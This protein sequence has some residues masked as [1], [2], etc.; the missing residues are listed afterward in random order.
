MGVQGGCSRGV[1]RLE[2]LQGANKK[3]AELREVCVRSNNKKRQE[4]A[5]TRHGNARQH[6]C[7]SGG[8]F[9]IWWLELQ[10][11]GCL[12][13]PGSDR[14]MEHRTPPASKNETG[15]KGV[16]AAFTRDGWWWWLTT[17]GRLAGPSSAQ[18]HQRKLCLADD[19]IPVL[20]CDDLDVGL[21]VRVLLVLCVVAIV[22]IILFIRPNERC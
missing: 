17:S 10:T 21:V 19:F 16:R 7:S 6:A 1:L 13:A 20:G 5:A 4:A 8:Y 11:I 2:L 18:T 14:T 12:R 3:T 9:L 22:I 15:K